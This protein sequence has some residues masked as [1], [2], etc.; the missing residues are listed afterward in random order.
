MA[1]LYAQII[2]PLSLHNSY[3]YSVPEPMQQIIL[4]GHRVIVQFGPKRLYAGLVLSL[5]KFIDSQIEIKEILQILD[6][7]PV[8]MPGNLKLWNWIAGYYCCTLGDVFRA[9]LPTGLKLESKSRIV[10]TGLKSEI[11]L[12][13][14]EILLMQEVKNGPVFLSEIQKKAG[15]NF[16][17]TTLKSLQQKNLIAVEEKVM[18]K[19]LPKT[20]TFVKFHSKITS[21]S[22]LNEHIQILG[23]AKKQLALVYHFCHITKAFEKEQIISISKKELLKETSF[24]AAILNELCRKNFLVQYQKVIS[25]LEQTNDGQVEINMLNPHQQ[26]AFELIQKAFQSKKVTLIHGITASGK[27]EIYI[28]LIDEIIKTGRQVLYLVPEIALTTQIIRRLK[29]VFGNTVGI[30]H[31]K[32]NSRERVE[33]WEKVLQFRENTETGYQ[34]I[35]GARSALFLPFVNLGLI[36]VDEEH[37]TSY[38]QHDPMPRYN[39]RDMAVVLGS[40]QNAKVLLGSATPSVESYYNTITGKYALVNL[41]KKHAGTESP[42]MIIADTKRARKRKQMHS[43]LTPEL[44]NIMETALDER[45]QVILFQN[46]RG[47]SPFIECFTCGWIPKCKNCDVS[48]TYHKYKKRLSCHYCGYSVP[49]PNSCDNC[50]SPEVKTRGFG[51]EKIEDELKSLFRNARI[52]RMDLDTTQSKYSF[53]KIVRNIE[54]QKTDILVGTQMVTKGLDFEHVSVIGILNADNLINFPDFRA[55]ERAYQLISQ[56]SG[57]AGRKHKQGK[58]II[59]TTQPEHQLLHLVQNQDY[60]T[61]M[62]SQLNERHLFKYPP[63]YRLIKI[64]V[65]H[66]KPETVDRVALHLANVLKKNQQFIVLGPEY[67]LI[68]KVKQWYNKEIWLKLN[69]KLN[70]EKSKSYILSAIE[71]VKNLPFNSNCIINVDV[72]PF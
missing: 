37:D 2:L 30:Y 45:E 43:V 5:S 59:Q 53:D 17:Y 56:V 22:V 12:N 11:T 54:N 28:H 67:P 68:G 49:F 24:S 26:E 50:G 27:T 34:V 51:T 33:I 18:E 32:L 58:V 69:R 10:P 70:L 63:F 4:P 16:S 46:R 25:R 40:Q 65:K 13:D 55:H 52:V 48:L 42:E 57:R 15:S 64:M 31:S 62:N 47:Y 72:D 71:G 60:I 14:K 3:T 21:E 7:K 20:E 6:E 39:A 66:K 35:L 8:V 29:N 38:K 61:M 19:Y 44:Y 36:V 23:R 9:A 41:S 1:E